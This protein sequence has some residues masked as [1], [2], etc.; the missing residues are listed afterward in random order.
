MGTF[1]LSLL[2]LASL[3]FSSRLVSSHLVSSRLVDGRVKW[4]TTQ[5]MLMLPKQLQMAIKRMTETSTVALCKL[6]LLLLLLLVL[7]EDGNTGKRCRV[8]T[9]VAVEFKVA[10]ANGWHQVELSER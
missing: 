1:L 6:L 7:V 3:L 9:Q 5:A 8:A 2:I 10:T 4:T